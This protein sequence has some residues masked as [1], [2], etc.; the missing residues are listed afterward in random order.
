M[1]IVGR[2]RGF[3][4][5]EIL[6]VLV[7]I[8]IMLGVVAPRLSRDMGVSARHEGLRLMALL[9]AARTEAIVT[10]R[11]YRVN[12]S[13]HGYAFQ[14]L[15]GHGRFKAAKG[16]LFRARHLPAGAAIQGLGK[17]RAVVFTP[18]GLGQVFHCE[19]VT[20]HGRFLVSG[21]DDGHIKGVAR[22]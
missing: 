13:A 22:G 18:S 5:L 11:P 20:R 16:V 9:K 8:G 6:V 17:E 3:T 10:G 12:F 14:R 19:I 15:N 4:L 21:N 7:L 2:H 1:A